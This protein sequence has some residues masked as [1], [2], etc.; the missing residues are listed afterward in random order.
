MLRSLLL[1]LAARHRLGDWMERL[2]VGRRLVRRFVPGSTA[3]EALQAMAQLNARGLA[4]AVTYLGENVLTADDARHAAEVYIDLLDA[5]KRRSLDVTPSLKLTHLGLDLSRELCLDNLRR[6][7]DRGRDGGTLVWI[8]MESSAYTDRTLDMYAAL[9]REYPGVGC[10]I[11]AYLHRSTVD[12]ERLIELGA[13]VRLCKGAYREPP[14]V[15]FATKRE[16]D[17]SYARLAERLLSP[18]ATAR[19]VYPGFATHDQRL[20]RHVRDV[21]RSR[22]IDPECFEIQMLCG[23]RPD[24]HGE[25]QASGLRL[26]VLVPFGEAWY[27]YFVRRLAERPANVLFLLGSLVRA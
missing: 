23:I 22:G 7:L 13:S 8:D 11:Q 18:E 2:P 1:F 26:R 6:V 3:A 21:S 24:V 17:L 16:V 27:G 25:I 9:R 15:A 19:G 12:V 10:V 4:A 14:A 5:I 20:V